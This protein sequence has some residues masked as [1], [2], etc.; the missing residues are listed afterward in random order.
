MPTDLPRV[1][2]M[3][4]S[5]SFP[6]FSSNEEETSCLTPVLAWEPVIVNLPGLTEKGHESLFHKELSEAFGY[7][8]LACPLATVTKIVLAVWDN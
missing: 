8:F 6:R 4:V 1:R 7:L 3:L 2:Q 5:C